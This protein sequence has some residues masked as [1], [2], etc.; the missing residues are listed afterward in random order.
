V[1]AAYGLNVFGFSLP[2]A[3]RHVSSGGCAALAESL[4]V[5]RHLEAGSVIPQLAV[6]L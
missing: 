6:L 1:H 4:R 5:R 2:L 3:A